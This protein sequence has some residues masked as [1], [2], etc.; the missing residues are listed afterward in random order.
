MK[1]VIVHDFWVPNLQE[2]HDLEESKV[3]LKQCG[4]Q[5]REK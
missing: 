3:Q 5:I 1:I 2:I 4:D